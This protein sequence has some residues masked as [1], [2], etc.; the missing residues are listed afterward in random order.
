MTD[1]AG[2][3][4]PARVRAALFPGPAAVWLTA[5]VGR[6]RSVIAGADARL[7]RRHVHLFP[8]AHRQSQVDA[9][10]VGRL[11]RSAGRAKRVRNPRPGLKRVHTGF[12]YC[13][14]H[15]D[16]DALLNKG[17]WFGA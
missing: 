14:G 13:A 8:V 9:V 11:Q 5:A 15:V 3:G 2:T 10:S 4:R 17:S 6:S 16:N 1:A 7:P 12:R